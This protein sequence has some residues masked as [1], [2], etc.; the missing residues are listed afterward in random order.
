MFINNTYKVDLRPTTCILPG[1]PKSISTIAP[2]VVERVLQRFCQESAQGPHLVPFLPSFSAYI[3]DRETYLDMSHSQK[4]KIL[5]EMRQSLA[6]ILQHLEVVIGPDVEGLV[7]YTDNRHDHTTT[8]RI[9]LTSYMFEALSQARTEAEVDHLLLL[10]VN[11]TIHEISHIWLQVV[12][13]FAVFT[14]HSES[15]PFGSSDILVL[16]LKKSR[17]VTS[18]GRPAAGGMV[19]N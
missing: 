16:A 5:S 17:H 19:G 2:Y 8:P 13:S 1:G 11:A 18:Q 14:S 10:L 6:E 15:Q 4:N 9:T 3:H 12:S 7:A